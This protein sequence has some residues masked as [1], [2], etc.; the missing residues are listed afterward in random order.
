MDELDIIEKKVFLSHD[1]LRDGIVE[2]IE[3]H[4]SNVVF[5][6]HKSKMRVPRYENTLFIV[7]VVGGLFKG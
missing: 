4:G 7:F 6:V 3:S 1:A 5:Y 2:L